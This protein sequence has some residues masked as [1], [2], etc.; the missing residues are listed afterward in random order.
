MHKLFDFSIVFV[1]VW[2]WSRLKEGDVLPL[3]LAVLAYSETNLL[4]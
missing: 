4:V 3:T 1:L 2:S